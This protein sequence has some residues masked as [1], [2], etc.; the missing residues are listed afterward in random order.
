LL[1]KL[2]LQDR[3]QLDPRVDRN[4]RLAVDGVEEADSGD[5]RRR[6]FDLRLERH[7]DVLLVRAREAFD[8]SDE[9]LRQLRCVTAVYLGARMSA[10]T[11]SKLMT[12][13]SPL[14]ID[15]KD[16]LIDAYSIDFEPA[17]GEEQR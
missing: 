8:G 11:R 4:S 9:A 6:G 15:V 10:R 13:L 3:V 7:D 12:A 14:G 5:D 17:N 2:D 1:R 16:M